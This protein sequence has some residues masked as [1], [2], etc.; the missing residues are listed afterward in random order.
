MT[1][2]LDAAKTEQLL[3]FEKLAHYR[4]E[5]AK[6]DWQFEHSSD[7][8][9]WRQGVEQLAYLRSVQKQIDPLYEIWNQIAHPEYRITL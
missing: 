5:L 9:V 1:T 6:F 7:Q 2:P 8:R 4:E 3:Y